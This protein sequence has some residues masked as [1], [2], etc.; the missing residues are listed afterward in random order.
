MRAPA[1]AASTTPRTPLD[2]DRAYQ[3]GHRLPDGERGDDDPDRE[4]AVAPE[5]GGGHLHRRWVHAREEDARGEAAGERGGIVGRPAERRV[6]GRPEQSADGEVPPGADDVGEVE[7]RRPGGPHHE[8]ELHR[9]GEPPRLARGEVPE[10]AILSGD[11]AGGEPERHPQHLGQREEAEHAPP[12][13]VAQL[14]RL[15]DACRGLPFREGG[16]QL[17]AGR[18]QLHTEPLGLGGGVGCEVERGVLQPYP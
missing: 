15:H 4:A 2:V 1:E 13:S 17:G 14:D 8:A 11:R 7:D 18:L 6:G 12:A 9:G 16:I 5:P 10:G 3:V